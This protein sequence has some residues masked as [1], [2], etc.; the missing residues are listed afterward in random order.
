MDNPRYDF[1]KIIGNET[2]IKSIKTAAKNGHVSHA[3][4]VNGPAGGGKKLLSLTF[5]KA[6]LCGNTDTG[7]AC[8]LC[9]SCKTL[10]A[11][12][13]PDVVFVR[14]AK[15]SLG[16][17]DIREQVVEGA[18]IM[19]YSSAR[20]V[21]IIENA[22][23]MTP[24]AQNALLKTLE[25]PRHCVFFLLSQ[26]CDAFLPTIISR[27]VVYKIAPL[28]AA[29]VQNHLIAKGF[30]PD[31]AQTAAKHAGGAIGRGE[32]IAADKDFADLHKVIT[33][34][35]EEVGDK[36]I[37]AIFEAAKA[38]EA[39]KD[40]IEDALDMLCQYY[41]DVLVNK[42]IQAKLVPGNSYIKGLV[43]KIDITNDARQKLKRNC[44]FLL[45]MEVMLLK[46]A[47]ADHT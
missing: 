12:S 39:Y 5:A 36:D 24:Q 32:V 30:D 42:S 37:P 2:I 8:D 1:N 16:V 18:A 6:V 9:K 38:L 20:R 15:K 29:A 46:L 33:S 31:V 45:T 7:D 22:D 10:E 11:G 4:I 40:R 34:L 27:C 13:H 14:P 47:E 41:R 21:F 26:N 17:D 28:S 19:P 43:R 44:N 3:Y 35:A 23:L 25:E